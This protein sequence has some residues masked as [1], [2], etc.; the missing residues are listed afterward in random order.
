MLAGQKAE[1]T[2]QAGQLRELNEAKS[3]FLT[4]ITH[5]FRILRTLLLGP[6][7]QILAESAQPAVRQHA[8]QVPRHAKHLLF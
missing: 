4:N 3:R 1:I 8:T 7:R 6:A 5:E 2:A